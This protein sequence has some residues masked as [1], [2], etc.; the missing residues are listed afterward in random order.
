MNPKT[1]A[2]KAA[3][4][5]REAVAQARGYVQG[6]QDSGW[7]CGDCGNQYDASVDTCPNRILDEAIAALRSKEHAQRS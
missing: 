7:E 6:V 3:A 1:K 5:A 2:R 4:A